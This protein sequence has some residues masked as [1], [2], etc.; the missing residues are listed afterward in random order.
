MTAPAQGRRDPMVRQV[1]M[2]YLARLQRSAHR[3]RRHTGRARR[4]GVRQRRIP[5]STSRDRLRRGKLARPTPISSAAGLGKCVCAAVPG[6]S[7]LAA[8]ACGAPQSHAL[9]DPRNPI[10]IR[11]VTVV[12]VVAGTLRPHTTV[13]VA[14]SR[15]VAVTA[16]NTQ[17]EPRGARTCR[18]TQHRTPAR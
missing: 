14:G 13:T 16:A 4:H 10:V 18:A 12:D 1:V 17:V 5:P 3:R 11:D 2:P 9:S 6:L 7:V 8:L 15:I